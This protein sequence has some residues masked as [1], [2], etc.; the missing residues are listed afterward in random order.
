MQTRSVMPERSKGA[1]LKT[2]VL[3]TRRFESCWLR[4][5]FILLANNEGDRGAVRCALCWLNKFPAPYPYRL[6]AWLIYLQF[7]R[8]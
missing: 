4:I 1:V 7:I 5:F 6:E 3:C 8:E 2:V